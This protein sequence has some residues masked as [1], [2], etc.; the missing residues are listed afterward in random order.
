M[1]NSDDSYFGD[2]MFIVSDVKALFSELGGCSCQAVPRKSNSLAHDLAALAFF[3]VEE[4][5]WRDVHPSCI[6]FGRAKKEEEEETDLVV[7]VTLP[8]IAAVF[9]AVSSRRHRYWSL[10]S[11]S[12]SSL[13][14]IAV[15][16][17]VAWSERDREIED[18]DDVESCV[19]VV[20]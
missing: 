19:G 13:L 1:L 3:S 4:L 10:P 18:D 6:F 12:P 9:V 16:V 5:L 14:V 7:I 17:V 15:A 8:V 20:W 2:A 11:P